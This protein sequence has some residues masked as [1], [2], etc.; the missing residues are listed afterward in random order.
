MGF[1]FPRRIRI[2][3]GLRLNL[4]KS[5]IG[6]SAR[7]TG[8]R[9]GMDPKEKR[10]VS[11][12]LPGTGLS[13][14]ASAPKQVTARAPATRKQIVFAVVSLALLVASLVL[15]FTQKG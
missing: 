15:L 12:G 7:R 2:A 10:Y 13:Y 3:P 4:S 14:R 9:F 1:R 6:F 11:V 8:L 5:G